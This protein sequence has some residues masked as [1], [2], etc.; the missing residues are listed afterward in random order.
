MEPRVK[1]RDLKDKISDLAHAFNKDGN[2]LSIDDS[3]GTG[4]KVNIKGKDYTV[5][6]LGDVNGDGEVD[7]IDMALVKRDIIGT[8]KLTGIYKNA[9]KVSN[10]G[11]EIDIIDMA[12]IKRNIIGTSNITL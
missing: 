7:I 9:G 11:E 12:L 1:V 8:Q 3:M 4:D 10:S 5:V 2:E 6:K